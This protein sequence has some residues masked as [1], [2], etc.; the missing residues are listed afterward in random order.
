MVTGASRGIGAGLAAH[1]AGQGLRL[2]LCARTVPAAPPGADGLAGAVDV[3][4]PA[5]WTPS[6]TRW[7]TASVGSTCGSTTPGCSARSVRWPRPTRPRWRAHV[8]VNVL[9]RARARPPSPGTCAADPGEGT[10]VNLSSGAATSAYRGW[11]AYCASKAAVEMLTEVVG[12]EERASGLRAYA[13]APGVVDTDMQALIR[14]TPDEDFPAV[15]RFRALHAGRAFASTA[16]VARSILEPVRRPGQP[17][18]PCR[19]PGIRRLPGSRR[20][21]SFRLTPTLTGA[22]WSGTPVDGAG[23]ARRP[24]TGGAGPPWRARAGGCGTVGVEGGQLVGDAP[25]QLRLG[26]CG[27]DPECAGPRTPGEVLPLDVVRPD[28]AS[29]PEL[30]TAARAWSPGR[31]SGVKPSNAGVAARTM[32]GCGESVAAVDDREDGPVARRAPVRCLELRKVLPCMSSMLGA[33][34]KGHPRRR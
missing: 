1:F 31:P 17:A 6:P 27:P 11:A 20:A 9:G 32:R 26:T 15:A 23:A 21:P 2:G 14:S 4:R 29:G 5:R 30:W 19:R 24:T 16:W 18:R 8:A 12:L 10:L 22:P 25:D 33:V 3:T 34:P 7:S 28:V 13:V